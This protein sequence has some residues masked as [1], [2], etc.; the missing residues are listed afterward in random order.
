MSLTFGM[1]S[2]GEC[3]QE[4]R[5]K[6]DQFDKD[7]LNT[8]LAMECAIAGWSV[9]DWIFE[10]DG[11]RLGY[12]KLR[13]L[14]DEIRE[15]C[16]SLSHLQ[17]IANAR[18]HKEID[19]YTPSVKSSGQREGDFNRDFSRDFNITRLV[20]HTDAGEFSFWSTLQSALYYYEKYFEQ[21][22]IT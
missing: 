8:S 20:F 6:I 7:D 17:D 15:Q 16:Q 18:K 12:N 11:Q 9:A 22:K 21:N 1:K 5:N 13:D 19:H 3:L 2:A 10:C 14:Q 4:F